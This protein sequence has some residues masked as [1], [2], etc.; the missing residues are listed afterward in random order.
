MKNL[1]RI[2]FNKKNSI[3]FLDKINP[4]LNNNLKKYV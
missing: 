1:P 2:I 4:K 3:H